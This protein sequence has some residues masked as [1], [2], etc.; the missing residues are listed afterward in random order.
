M[1]K[2]TAYLRVAKY[3]GDGRRAPFKVSATARPN[4]T[5]LESGTGVPLPTLAF[6]VVLDIPDS[7]FKQAEQVI[8]EIRIPE[9][10][11]QIAAE[12]KQ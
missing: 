12:V 7:A 3:G 8:A 4:H 9:D 6:A 10:A 1:S 11:L 5:P 2:V